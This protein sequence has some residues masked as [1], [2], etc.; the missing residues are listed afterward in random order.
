VQQT[1]ICLFDALQSDKIC[2][3]E[4]FSKAAPNPENLQRYRK[5]FRIILCD[6]DGDIETGIWVIRQCL[7][8]I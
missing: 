4:V 2:G 3:A 1:A 6:D 7:N 5:F 8:S